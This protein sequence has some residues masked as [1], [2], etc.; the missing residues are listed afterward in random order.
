MECFCTVYPLN[1]RKSYSLSNAGENCKH[2]VNT[3]DDCMNSTG[4]L[5]GAIYVLPKGDGNQ[6]PHGCVLDNVTPG[7]SYVYWNEKGGVKSFDPKLR[8]VCQI[9]IPEL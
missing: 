9:L 7:K 2:P 8:T 4:S 3:T 1:R 6:F 5:E